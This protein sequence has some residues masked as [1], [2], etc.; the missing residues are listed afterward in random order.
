MQA[1]W[2]WSILW[3]LIFVL[4]LPLLPFYLIPLHCSA[5]QMYVMVMQLYGPVVLWYTAGT[6]IYVMVRLYRASKITSWLALYPSAS[7]DSRV[8]RLKHLVLMRGYKEPLELMFST[9]NSLR[10][11]TVV[12]DLVVV[13]AL[14]EGSPAH[15]D[16]AFYNEYAD[17]FFDM[18]VTRHPRGWTA[19]ERPGS[20]SNSNYAWRAIV[21]R[22]HDRGQLDREAMI[23]TS[24]DTDSV[25][26]AN[27]FEC[28]GHEFLRHKTPHDVIWQAPLFYNLQLD[29]RPWFVRC[30]GIM[31]TAFMCGFLIGQSLNPMSTFSYSVDLLIRC[32]FIHPFHVMD[33]VVHIVTCM[34]TLRKHVPVEL[35]P[36]VVVSGPTSGANLREEWYEWGRQ[37]RRWCIGTMAVYHY[38]MSKQLRGNFQAWAGFT[39]HLLFTHYY[40]F[41]L[42][43]LL[44]TSVTGEI[45]VQ[46][47]MHAHPVCSELSNGGYSSTLVS[48]VASGS[49][50][51]SYAAFVVFFILDR[52]GVSIGEIEEQLPL[53]R[54]VLHWLLCWPTLFLYNLVQVVSS[55]EASLRGQTVIWHNAAKKDSLADPRPNDHDQLQDAENASGK[56]GGVQLQV[57]EGEFLSK[58]SSQWD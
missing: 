50:I 29:Q 57:N 31:R 8:S 19:M 38:F 23:C 30:T 42:C 7:V 26:P 16:Q 14:E 37:V 58:H 53:W 45:A 36:I 21:Q 11:Q 24:C 48:W 10:E 22:L 49:L 46:I 1:F 56:S 39:Y 15:Y 33:D 54:N 3:T 34:K 9:I 20:C 25:F 43:S 6:C 2:R 44:F 17:T 5:G 27:Y 55:V 51:A 52:V 12:K 13:V 4:G 40:G 32:N 41:I 47:F 35:V 28:V 18:I